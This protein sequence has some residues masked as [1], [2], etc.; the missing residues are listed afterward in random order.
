MK[1]PMR[2]IPWPSAIAGAKTSAVFQPG[3]FVFRMYQTDTAS[4]ASSPP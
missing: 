2:P 4:A 3:S 1:Q